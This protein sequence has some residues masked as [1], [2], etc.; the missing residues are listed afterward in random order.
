MSISLETFPFALRRSNESF[1]NTS[2][3]LPPERNYLDP[4]LRDA[5]KQVGFRHHRRHNTYQ[6]AL[7]LTNLRGHSIHTNHHVQ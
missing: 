3:A 7:D 6:H 1:L 4:A 5:Y 2:V